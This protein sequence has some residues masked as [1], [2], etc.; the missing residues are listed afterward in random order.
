[1]LRKVMDKKLVIINN[2]S[3]FIQTKPQKQETNIKIWLLKKVYIIKGKLLKKV[4]II[5]MQQLKKVKITKLPN[6][7]KNSSWLLFPLWKKKYNN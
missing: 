6:T 4:L 1:M 3:L 2:K 7:Q 5:K